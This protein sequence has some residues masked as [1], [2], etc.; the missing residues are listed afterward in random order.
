MMEFVGHKESN[1]G[2]MEKL[3]NLD[4]EAKILLDNIILNKS[5]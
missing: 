2:I 4:I 3:E 1:F 5:N